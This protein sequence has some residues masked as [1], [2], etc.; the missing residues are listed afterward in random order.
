MKKKHS[1]AFLV[2][3]CV[4]CTVVSV[5]CSMLY[6]YDGVGGKKGLTFIGKIN[7]VR[8]VIDNTYVGEPD[9]ELIADS[10]G[11]AMVEAVEDRWSYYLTA[12]EYVDYMNS[13]NNITSGIGISILLDEET[14]EIG[15]ISVSDNSPAEKA[16]VVAGDILLTVAGQEVTGMQPADIRTIVQ[17]QED[18]FV[19][20][21]R[22]SDGQEREVTVKVET[23]HSNP[24]SYEML[25]NSIGYIR[26]ANFDAGCA[27]G[28]VEAIESLQSEGMQSLIFDVRTNP[29]GLLDELLELLDYILPEGDTFVSVSK[30][31]EEY[32]YTSEAA[33]M[34]KIPMVVMID[35]N[36]YSA[37]EFFAAAL[38]EYGYA[39]LIGE[40]STGK[41]RSQQTFKLSDGSAVHISTRGYL[42][43]HRRDLTEE[44]GLVPDII[45]GSV[46]G[47]DSQLEEAT[48][49]LS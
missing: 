29:G 45:V 46:V 14:G 19:I 26:I 39:T 23:F 6:V 2:L 28:T 24:V 10:A 3:C 27:E 4:A 20:K 13:V 12:G 42:T 35:A 7:E 47:K 36:S 17:A 48:K 16:G 37:A 22:G 1:T 5:V 31:G 44:G 9:W 38:S 21:L 33:C 41:S 49:Y 40:A 15:I 32:V 18:E 30:D 11:A 8:S 43:P 34:E 25:D